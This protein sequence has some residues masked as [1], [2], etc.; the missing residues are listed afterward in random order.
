MMNL[1]Y[2]TLK[3]MKDYIG[4]VLYLLSSLEQGMFIKKFNEQELIKFHH[5][6]ILKFIEILTLYE[7]IW[8]EV[9]G[10]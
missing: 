9:Y 3:A 5:N 4:V 10:L 1:G 2:M 7:D 8:V 6:I